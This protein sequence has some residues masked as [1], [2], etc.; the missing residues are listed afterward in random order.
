MGQH[1]LE[2]GNILVHCGVIATWEQPF[3]IQRRPMG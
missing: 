3:V 2:E 1:E